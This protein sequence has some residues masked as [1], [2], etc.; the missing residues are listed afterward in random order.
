MIKGD[1]TPRAKHISDIYDGKK[2]VDDP[3]KKLREHLDDEN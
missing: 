1:L 2:V 3:L